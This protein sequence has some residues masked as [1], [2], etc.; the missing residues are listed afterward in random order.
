MDLHLTLRKNLVVK[1]AETFFRNLSILNSIN[2]L[3]FN[4]Y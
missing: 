3:F 1:L 2:C 4:I